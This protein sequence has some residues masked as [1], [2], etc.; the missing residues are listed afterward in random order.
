MEVGT[1]PGDPGME[2]EVQ[3]AQQVEKF[4]QKIT[5]RFRKSDSNE[6]L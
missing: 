4:F 5:R 2:A 6:S 1:E 3:G